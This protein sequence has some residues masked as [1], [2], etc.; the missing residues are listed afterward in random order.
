MEIKNVQEFDDKTLKFE[1][2]LNPSETA[3]VVSFGLN[4][5]MSLGLIH[6]LPTL[7]VEEL[8]VPDEATLN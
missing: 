4:A 8:V 6:L 2:V 7:S 1:G 5:L 3:I